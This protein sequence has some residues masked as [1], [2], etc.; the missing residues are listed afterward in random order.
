MSADIVLESVVLRPYTLQ[1]AHEVLSSAPRPD[2]AE[3][4]PTDG[5]SVVCALLLRA[6]EAEAG[7]T[8]PTVVA[9]WTGPWQMRARIADGSIAIGGIGFKGGPRDGA[10][11]VGYGMAA[12]AHGRGHMTAAVTAL[13]ELARAQQVRVIAETEPGN[14]ASERVLLRCGFVIT[15]TADDGNTWWATA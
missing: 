5:D 6:D 12:S 14:V 11:E 4:F 13:V 3:D 8:P 9:P 2:W 15:H 7:Y 10:V 1:M